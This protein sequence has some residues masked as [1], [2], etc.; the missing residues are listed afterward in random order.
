[1]RYFIFIVSAYAIG[2]CSGGCAVVKSNDNDVSVLVK[3]TY[4]VDNFI[5]LRPEASF[6]A[7]NISLF[8]RNI[9][10]MRETFKPLKWNVIMT[11]Y[12]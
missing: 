9:P 10:I 1:M 4:T 6:K 3:E 2:L 12:I 11:S 7:L 8:S 5:R